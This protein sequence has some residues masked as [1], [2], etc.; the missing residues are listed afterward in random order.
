MTVAITRRRFIVRIALGVG[1]CGVLHVLP[2]GCSRRD[3][4][5]IDL[6]LI[7][8]NPDD[9]LAMGRDY[10]VQFPAESV[11]EV[12]ERELDVVAFSDDP[13]QL[14]AAIAA[15]IRSDF[16]GRKLFAHRGWLFARSEGRLA[17]LAVL[18]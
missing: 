12:L 8:A 1:G 16:E 6:S 10:L 9:I 18:D 13:M 3:A 7:Y 17:A 15:R 4:V 11:P 2:T 14:R 5:G